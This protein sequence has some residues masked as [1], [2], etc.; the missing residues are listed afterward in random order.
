MEIKLEKMEKMGIKKYVHHQKHWDFTR[1]T[2]E[3]PSSG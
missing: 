2:L 3:I 1:K